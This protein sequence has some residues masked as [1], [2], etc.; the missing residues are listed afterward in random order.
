[1]TAKKMSSRR[2]WQVVSFTY[3][4]E[5]PTRFCH[6]VREP[7]IY[8]D[9][10]KAEV[11]RVRATERFLREILPRLAEHVDGYEGRLLARD[12]AENCTEAEQHAFLRAFAPHVWDTRAHGE[13]VYKIALREFFSNT[14]IIPPEQAPREVWRIAEQLFDP[15]IPQPILRAVRIVDEV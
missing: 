11:A 15:C 4:R 7:V 2:G 5:E 3:E 6:E 14:G 1:M 13:E 9:K 12:F 10:A 8:R